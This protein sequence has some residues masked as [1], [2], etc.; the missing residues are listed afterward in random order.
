[1]NKREYRVL[2]KHCFLM[3]K[4]AVDAKQWLDKYHDEF[5]PAKSTV[6]GWYAEFK[7]DRL[8]TEDAPRPGRRSSAVNLETIKKVQ[9]TILEDCRARVREIAV[10][11]CISHESIRTIL[12]D[13]LK[14]KKLC[15]Q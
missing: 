5:A 9:R 3:G 6:H 15:A 10:K 1:M 11:A 4:S 13:L 12:Q 2:I 8:E 7:R 14:V